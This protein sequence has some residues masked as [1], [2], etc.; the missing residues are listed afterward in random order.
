MGSHPEQSDLEARALLANAKRPLSQDRIADALGLSYAD[1]SRLL[2]GLRAARVVEIVA[3]RT[4]IR[5]RLTKRTP[6]RGEP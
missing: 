6:N 3:T 4:G 1:T 2:S 5:Y